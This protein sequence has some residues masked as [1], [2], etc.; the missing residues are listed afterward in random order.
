MA[1]Q[2]IKA[3]LDTSFLDVECRLEGA[4]VNWDYI[5]KL[6]K[7]EQD[8]YALEKEML[9]SQTLEAFNF[10]KKKRLWVNLKFAYSFNLYLSNPCIYSEEM[11]TIKRAKDWVFEGSP[12]EWE[13][14]VACLEL[15]F[16]AWPSKRL[17]DK[18]KDIYKLLL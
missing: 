14:R 5:R 12:V 13:G 15:E 17:L 3:G 8:G 7:D 16:S 10:F 9:S 11:E 2:V 4:R 18:A 1:L 6:D